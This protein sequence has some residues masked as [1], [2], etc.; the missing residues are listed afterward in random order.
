MIT[1]TMIASGFD[2]RKSRAFLKNYTMEEEKMISREQRRTLTEL[3]MRSIEDDSERE[4]RLA[5][6]DDLTAKEATAEIFEFEM[7]TW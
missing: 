7:A 3:I 4:Y 1:N 6:L 5:A 2:S